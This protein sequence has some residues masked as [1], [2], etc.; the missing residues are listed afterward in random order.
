MLFSK[1]KKIDMTNIPQHIAIIMDGNGRWAKKRGLSRSFGHREG[2][3]TLR[4]IVEACYE[5]GVKYLTV[6]AFSTENWSRPK[7]EVDELMKLLLEYLRNAEKEIKGKNVRI[8]VIGDRKGLPEEI[9]TEIDRVEKNTQHISGLDFI[10]ALNY[11]GRQEIT[12]AVTRLIEDVKAGKVS[13]INEA[14][15]AKRLYTHDIPDPDL[16]IRTSGEIRL[17]NFLIWQSSYSELFFCDVLWP[18][19]TKKH[20]IEAIMSYQGRQRRFGGL[21]C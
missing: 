13:E 20:L 10:I 4:K 16:L 7:E 8:R 19:F 1:N 5:L 3:K 15:I 17:S 21:K 11:G 12:A 14:E 2:S 6:Y 18:D 9:R